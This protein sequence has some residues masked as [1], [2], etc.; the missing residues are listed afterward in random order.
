M[1]AAT[2]ARVREQAINDHPPGVEREV[3]RLAIA[4]WARLHQSGEVIALNER[5]VARWVAGQRGCQLPSINSVRQAL[6]D[7]GLFPVANGRSAGLHGYDWI[8]HPVCANW[9]PEQVLGVLHKPFD[10]V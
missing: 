10:L 2:L 8:S 3:A 9:R 7:H 1:S 6:G 4:V 5:D